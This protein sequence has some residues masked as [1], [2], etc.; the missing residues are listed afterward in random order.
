[1]YNHIL[2]P[3]DGSPLAEAVLNHIREQVAPSSSTQLTLLRAVPREMPHINEFATQGKID[4]PQAAAENEA[5]HYLATME[6][7]LCSAGYKVDTELSTK[8][9]A[10]AIIDYA[11]H[12]DVDLIALATHGRGG[13][14]RFLFGS[15][16]QKV[17]EATPVPVLVIRSR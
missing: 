15:V 17:L 7:R 8:M 12:H 6:D 14:G 10:D 4:N 1:M 9:P 2:I 11:E 3:L 13:I 16:T 5:R